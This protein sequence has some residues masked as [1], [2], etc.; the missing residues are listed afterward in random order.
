MH[1]GTKKN[2][3]HIVEILTLFAVAA[4]PPRGLKI[5]WVDL[6]A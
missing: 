2:K 6:I 3:H 1:I 4:A 5:C